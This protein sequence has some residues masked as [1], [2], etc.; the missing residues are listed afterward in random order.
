MNPVA[1]TTYVTKPN[2]YE[3]VSTTQRVEKMKTQT[4]AMCSKKGELPEHE[5]GT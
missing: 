4:V 3:A 1:L 5:I 2:K